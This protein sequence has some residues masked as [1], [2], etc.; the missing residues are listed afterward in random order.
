MPLGGGGTSVSDDLSVSRR[1]VVDLP[2][3]VLR[4]RDAL[5]DSFGES[6]HSRIS[7]RRTGAGALAQKPSAMLPP[8]S[9]ALARMVIHSSNA[10]LRSSLRF[11]QIIRSESVL[12]VFEKVTLF[13]R[14]FGFESSTGI[15]T[16]Q[17]K[18]LGPPAIGVNNR[19]E[20]TN[21]RTAEARKTLLSGVA[22]VC[23]RNALRAHIWRA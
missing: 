12:Q 18:C 9:P 23:Q 5:R 10:A 14:F 20:M 8:V 13:F 1:R 11:L 4:R 15:G 22:R 2:L 19:L 17:R 7:T 3:I 21:S 16:C 6:A